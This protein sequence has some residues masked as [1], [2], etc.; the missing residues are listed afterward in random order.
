M[1]EFV[2]D[3]FTTGEAFAGKDNKYRRIRKKIP[4]FDAWWKATEAGLKAQGIKSPNVPQQYGLL[5]GVGEV[6]INT[7]NLECK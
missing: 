6:P 1:P 2:A 5:D 3:L 4:E 7:T